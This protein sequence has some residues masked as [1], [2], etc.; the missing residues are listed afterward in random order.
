MPIVVKIPGTTQP[1]RSEEALL[2]IKLTK[3]GVF[4][5]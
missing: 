5:N 1:R 4:S 3:K 2:Q